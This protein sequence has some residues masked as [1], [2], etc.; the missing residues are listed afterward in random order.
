VNPAQ[1][2]V[3]LP[4]GLN[5]CVDIVLIPCIDDVDIICQSREPMSDSS[6]AANDNKFDLMPDQEREQFAEIRFPHGFNAWTSTVLRPHA[7]LAQAA[8]PSRTSGIVDRR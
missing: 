3:M 8:K 1:I 6:T 2:G 7:V 4:E 5:Q